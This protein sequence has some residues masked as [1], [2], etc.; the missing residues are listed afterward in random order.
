MIYMFKVILYYLRMYLKILEINV[1][2]YMILIQL[3]FWV[4]WQACLKI[5]GVELELL[6]DVDMLLM[7]EKGIRSGIC[8]AVTRHVKSK[9]KYM[10]DNY[11]DK[12]DPSY[13]QYYD[14]NSLYAWAMCRKLPVDGFK[15]SNNILEFNEEFIKIMTRILT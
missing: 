11:D 12:R 10:G 4:A 6:K 13:T 1:S 9:N 8:Q 3:I 14:A 7:V 2:K 5:N 15:W